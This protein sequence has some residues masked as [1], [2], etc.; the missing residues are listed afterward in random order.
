MTTGFKMLGRLAAL[1]VL[2]QAGT[3]GYM[4]FAGYNAG[5]ARTHEITGMMILPIVIIVMTLIA[6]VEKLSAGIK[7]SVAL[8][9]MI[10]VQIGLGE[11]GSDMPWLGALHV[12]LALVIFGAAS[13]AAVVVDRD[14]S[15]SQG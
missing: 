11:V 12:V 3:S 15:A 7:Y 8:V 5:A 14:K 6:F 10:I 9:V 2:V 13:M 4:S 1:L